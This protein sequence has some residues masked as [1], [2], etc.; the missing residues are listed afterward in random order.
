MSESIFKKK[1]I[2]VGSGGHASSVIDILSFMNEWEV[3]GVISQ[4]LRESDSYFGYPVLG[5]DEVIEKLT[6][7]D[8]SFVIAVGQ[9]KSSNTRHK[10]YCQLNR[11]NAKLPVIVSP[12]AYISKNTNIGKGSMVF[13]RVIIN[14][15]VS[16]GENCILNNMCL[17]EHDT[18]IGS[19]THISTGAVVNGNVKI[20]AHCFIGSGSVIANNV[21]ICNNVVLGAGSIVVKDLIHEG[22]YF[23]NPARRKS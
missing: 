20:G 15:N 9:I 23:G 5:N 3:S 13:H 1:I 21:T 17:I 10:I 7:N 12:D 11:F 19:H 6:Q 18:V 2:V 14:T 4:D 16:V 22:I 8:Y